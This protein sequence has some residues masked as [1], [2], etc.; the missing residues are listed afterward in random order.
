MSE[1]VKESVVGVLDGITE[2]PSGW[3]EISVRVEGWQYPVKMAQLGVEAIAK[4][5]RTGEKPAVTPGLDFYDT[6]VARLHEEAPRGG[7][8]AAARDEAAPG[9]DRH[10]VE[11]QLGGHGDPVG[12]R[13]GIGALERNAAQRRCGSSLRPQA[14]ACRS[15]SSA[16]CCATRAIGSA[17]R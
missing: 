8:V 16:G 7:T 5:K 13:Q 3:T 1:A 17:H 9:I 12:H 14:A 11:P 10:H 15:T 2:K 6:G 4:F